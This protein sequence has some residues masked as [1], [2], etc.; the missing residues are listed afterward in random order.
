MAVMRRNGKFAGPDDHLKNNRTGYY[1]PHCAIRLVLT[2]AAIENKKRQS[3]FRPLP[4]SQRILK[5]TKANYASFDVAAKTVY[6][7]KI[8]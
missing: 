3:Q 7:L 8:G 6:I 5:P 4:F 2:F 1:L